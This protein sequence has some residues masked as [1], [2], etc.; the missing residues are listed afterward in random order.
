[1]TLNWSPLIGPAF[2]YTLGRT[3]GQVRRSR[4]QAVMRS[5]T[6]AAGAGAPTSSD[7]RLWPRAAVS[8][9]ARSVLGIGCLPVPTARCSHFGQMPS[10]GKPEDR[11]V[12]G[13]WSLVAADRRPNRSHRPGPCG[14]DISTSTPAAMH[15]QE[16]PDARTVD[17]DFRAETAPVQ[18]S[19]AEARHGPIAGW[20]RH[21]EL[22]AWIGMRLP[23]DRSLTSLGRRVAPKHAA[24]PPPPPL[25]LEFG[26]GPAIRPLHGAWSAITVAIPALAVTHARGTWHSVMHPTARSTADPRQAGTGHAQWC[27]H[28]PRHAG[29]SRALVLACRGPAGLRASG[30]AARG[31][32]DAPLLSAR[33]PGVSA[34]RSARECDPTHRR[35]EC[36]LGTERGPFPG[37]P[38]PL[39]ANHRHPAAVACSFGR[40][41]LGRRV[42]GGGDHSGVSY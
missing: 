6:G 34:T 35:R 20:P 2:S 25:D 39:G 24:P 13:P 3:R 9:T 27:P 5:V 8:Q 40:L 22:R 26:P 29:L 12:L 21:E 38:R 36:V 18:W 14:A 41:F 11:V 31:P 28:V 10:A 7:P 30:S 42:A 32:A 17:I 15:G 19:A 4:S 23:I 16:C 1:M 33:L 37:H